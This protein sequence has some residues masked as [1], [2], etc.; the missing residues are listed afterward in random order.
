[1]H[2]QTI[3]VQCGVEKTTRKK[4]AISICTR[5]LK[6][7]SNKAQPSQAL[8]IIKGTDSIWLRLVHFG[9]G[10]PM[11]STVLKGRKWH[12]QS[13]KG[14]A[15]APVP[16]MCQHT[17]GFL[18]CWE[19]AVRLMAQC[20]DV[21]SV[22]SASGGPGS[23]KCCAVCDDLGDRAE[24]NDHRGLNQMVWWW[25]LGCQVPF[26][27]PA[28]AF[29]LESSGVNCSLASC[30]YK[31]TISCKGDT[32]REIKAQMQVKGC[33]HCLRGIC[34]PT[35]SPLL[36]CLQ[37]HV[38]PPLLYPLTTVMFNT[39][40]VIKQQVCRSPLRLQYG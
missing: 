9:Q 8:S 30:I 4:S 21:Y 33:D 36:C 3:T 22:N 19:S 10:Q 18:F 34:F 29:Q 6:K 2:I 25:H 26:T 23:L 16:V 12:V 31:T 35:S 17:L 1:M 32:G 40:T 28:L 11:V 27:L 5:R 20:T 14:C 24:V 7:R 39:N 15:T 37:D 38:F 13:S